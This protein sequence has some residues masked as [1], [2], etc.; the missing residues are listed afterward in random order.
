MTR[1]DWE[2]LPAPVRESVEARCGQVVKAEP[3][4]AGR[5]SD[6]AAILHLAGGGEVFCKG[7]VA[8]SQAATGQARE[9]RVNPLLPPPL[10]PR[11]LWQVEAEGWQLLAFE[12][13]A[14]QHANLSPD[15][16]DLPLVTDA[17]STM[18][19]ELADVDVD[20]PPMATKI[21]RMSAWNRLLADPPADV[22]PWAAP[23]LDEFATIER[24]T[25]E[26]IEGTALL[27]TDLHS[28]NI[29]VGERAW[30]IDWAWAQRGVAWLDAAILLIR[31]IEAGHTPAQAE[32][33]AART[34]AWAGA[35]PDVVT[36][37]A[38]S[39]FGLWEYL[40]LMRPLPNR[41]AAAA[42]ARDWTR[43]RI[44]E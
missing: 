18:A 25:C 41:P 34:P 35:N 8:A 10:A 44:E 19:V 17:V 32:A 37:F 29:L 42:A 31:L 6:F 9:A 3:P 13:V 36:G 15:S 28:L 7:V 1:Y 30:I 14:G 16:P 11:L 5:N 22:D 20:V 2:S 38:V 39:I 23:R 26:L 24:R 40:Q 21:D 4:A 43:Y 12:R 33:W 27:H